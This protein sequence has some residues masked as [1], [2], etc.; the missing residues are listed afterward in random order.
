MLRVAIV[1]CG[2]IADQHVQAIARI[3]DATVV[4][5][6]DR[7]A[8]MAGQL[9][10]R[11][12]IEH[13]SAD[14]GALLAS[15]RPDVVHITTPPRSHFP[16]AAQCLEAGCH[17]YVEKPFTVDT[18]EAVRLIRSAEARGLKITAG[19]NLQYTWES[20][21]ARQLVADGFLG[22]PA[23]HVE[24]YFTYNL[25]DASYAKALLGD[26]THWVRELPG[27]LLHNIISHGL[28]RVAEHLQTETA[29]VAAFGSTSR[30]LHEIGETDICDELRVHVTDGRGTTGTFVFST[31]LSPPV[32]GY[33]L[34]GPR[35]SLV[36]DNY[37]RT[38]TRQRQRPFKSY[39][40]YF[41]PP[42]L[43]ARENLRSARR[44]VGR[45]LRS[46]FHDDSG[47]KNLIQAFY[48]AVQGQAEVPISYREILL[49]SRMMDSVFEQINASPRA[50]A[51]KPDPVV[52][53]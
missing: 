28:A 12:R 25:G 29:T 35:N 8:L 45:F 3:P 41:L 37:H 46:E 48:E 27:K 19:H 15:A 49:T 43:S 13:S 11:Y 23:V 22:G 17:V 30:L 7:E 40:N 24:S 39:L 2:K 36:V 33:R 50:Q 38:L 18:D 47:L 34:Y 16:L 53:T 44:N 31:Q 6:C 51:G 32:N 52:M 9:A 14:L 5:V 10:E 4:G 42:V 1:G 20:I 21:E 26:R